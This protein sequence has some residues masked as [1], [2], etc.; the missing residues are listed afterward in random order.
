MGGMLAGHG[1]VLHRGGLTTLAAWDLKTA[2]MFDQAAPEEARVAPAAHYRALYENRKPPEGVIVWMTSYDGT[3]LSVADVLG[4]RG[5]SA[6]G[7]PGGTRRR[8][9]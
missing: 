4:D 3:Q 7:G 9:E 5:G 8:H 1:K 2:I 6:E